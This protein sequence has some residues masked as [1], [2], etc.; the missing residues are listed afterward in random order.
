MNDT[1]LWFVYSTVWYFMISVIGIIFFPLT[2]IIF[3]RFYDKGYGLSKALGIALITYSAFVLGTLRIVTFTQ[4]MLLLILAVWAYIN[5]QLYKRSTHSDPTKKTTPYFKPLIL[6]EEALCLIGFFTWSYVRAH[7]PAIHGLEKFMD[8]GFINSAL[9]GEYFPAQDMWMAGKAI[10]YYYFGHLTGAVLTKLSAVPSFISYNLILAH[11]FAISVVSSFTVAFNLA[12]HGFNKNIKLA[13]ITG[14]LGAFLT[15]LAGNLHTIYAFTMGYQNESPVPLWQTTAKYSFSDLMHPIAALDK[16]P[17]NYWYPNAT[18]FVPFTIHEFPLY[19]YVVADLHGHVFDIPF[20]LLTIGVLFT[21][22]LNTRVHTVKFSKKFALYC[23]LTGMLLSIHLMTN[24]FDA[25]IYLALAGI[26]LLSLLGFSRKLFIYGGIIFGSFLV[27]NTPFTWGFE[28]FAT[29]VGFNCVPPQFSSAIQSALSGTGLASKLIFENNCQSSQW[30]MLLTLWG[31]FWIHF[32]FFILYAAIKKFEINR[33]YIF[34]LI[35]FAFSTLLIIAPEFVYAKD[36]YPSHFRANTMFKLGYQ[37]FIL[38]SFASAFTCVMFKKAF[39]ELKL[40][41]VYLAVFI[42]ICALVALYPSFAT[43]SYYGNKGAISLDGEAWIHE[44]PTLAEYYEII[45]YFNTSVKGQPHILEAQGDSYTDYNLV[46]AYTG[47]PTIAGWYVHQWLW[48]GSPDA[49]GK[50]QPDISGIYE[51]YDQTKTL[52]KLREYDVQYVII[53]PN[54]R[55]KYPALDE[56]KFEALGKA[57]FKTKNGR[58]VVYQ[59]PIDTH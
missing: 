4:T 45:Q 15:N 6:F 48:R 40:A 57:I 35:L 43:S 19:S 11:L 25:P 29:G 30:W 34:I 55:T 13:M 46:S 27:F 56:G 38:M 32:I 28:P 51:A 41:K 39:K 9:R 49:V 8:F 18:R 2:R 21:M 42:P 50:L 24:A 59:I 44:S 16:L 3:S 37:A 53:G 47:L 54:E 52:Q 20:V 31:F 33:V 58:G 22:Y 26:V 23:V 36:I 14:T 10:N 5:Y 7:E 17:V 12:Y 1:S